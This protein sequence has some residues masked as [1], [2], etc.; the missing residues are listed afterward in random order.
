MDLIKIAESLIAKIKKDYNGDVSIVHVHG[1]YFYK[2]THELSDL[3]LYFVPKTERGFNLAK[4]FILNGIGFDYF[5]LSWERLERIA[6][7][8]EKLTALITDGEILYYHSE[9]D[10]ERFNRL[11]EKADKN[12]ADFDKGK[13]IL[14]DIYSD[15]FKIAE[16]KSLTEA[17]KVVIETIYNLSFLLA[18]INGAPIKRGRRNLK[19]E[20]LSMRLVPKDFENL[21]DRLFLEKNTDNIKNLL[22]A[23]IRNTEKLFPQDNHGTLTDN[24]SGFYEEMVQCYN[25]IFHAC[26][27][28]DIYTPLFSAAELTM[29]IEELFIKSNCSYELPDMVDSYDPENL[30]KIKET[31]KKHQME[32]VKVL[33][34]NG[35]QI[36]SFSSIGE[37]DGFLESIP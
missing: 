9:E 30:G 18:E 29:E 6:N 20:I 15:Y 36:R 21:Y 34:E 17:R 27:T 5:A 22:Y 31:A 11:K 4:T 10:L 23:L 28:G 14:K 3:D 24:F 35:V 7:H 32:F 16:C 13:E 26:D 2:N 25:K 12:T 37:L 19:N 8:E 1:S 33:M